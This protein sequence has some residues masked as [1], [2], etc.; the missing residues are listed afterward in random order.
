M[1][2]QRPAGVVLTGGVSERMGVDKATLVVDGTPMAVRVADALWEAGCQPVD[3]QGGD[4][5][6][7]LEYGLEALPDSEPGGGPL[8]AIRDAL[9]RH[10]ERDVV[11]AACDLVDLDAATVSRLIDAAPDDDTDDHADD[12]ADDHIEG[13]ERID[14]VVARSGSERHLVC[15]W[16]SGSA[17]R[18]GELLAAGVTSYRDALAQLRVRDVDVE[19]ETMRNMNTP[20][21]L[22]GRR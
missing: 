6:A 12:H 15:W 10:P 20:T 14:A 17:E 18:V 7:M 2:G 13:D 1:S 11:V 16:R 19:P 21:D 5:A 4:L 8:A 3:C 9:E 22:G